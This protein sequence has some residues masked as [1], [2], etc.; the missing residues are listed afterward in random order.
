MAIPF[1]IQDATRV[2]AP[3]L[4]DVLFDKVEKRFGTMAGLPSN[5]EALDAGLQF[6]VGIN[7]FVA[8]F[9]PS[10]WGKTHL[11]ESVASHMNR[12]FGT[13]AQIISAFDW[14]EGRHTADPQ[15]PL[16]LD[17]AHEALA[18]TRSRIQLRL[19]LERRVRIGRPTLLVATGE[20]MTRQIQS[21]LPSRREWK[22]NEIGQPSAAER[23]VIIE[24]MA[25]AENLKVAS[26]LA[27]LLASRM[28]GNGNTIHGALNTLK[29]DGSQWIMPSEILRACGLL[30]RF[31]ADNSAWDLKERIRT[32]AEKTALQ[33]RDV[34]PIKLSCYAMIQI[35]QLSEID[36]ARFSGLEPARARA[37]SLEFKKALLNLDSMESALNH[38]LY[39]TVESLSD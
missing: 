23:K 5:I 9:G 35:A 7:P 12:E 3:R 13:R 26:A 11:L 8:I 37:R 21:F 17:D 28:R 16:L 29:L 15:T 14:I 36:V 4:S 20:R 31:F 30:D 38:F 22:L 10:G 39:T 19:G 6:A 24:K 32:A 27:T 2:N 34:D 25:R 1:P 33:Y 18:R